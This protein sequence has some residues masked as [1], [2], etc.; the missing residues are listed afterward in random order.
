MVAT[1]G[2]SCNS[3]P[4]LPASIP[5]RFLELRPPR[6]WG[7]AADG[8]P[9]GPVAIEDSSGSMANGVVIH[10]SSRGTFIL[11]N[12]HV[13][14]E[15]ALASMSWLRAPDLE[16][17][18]LTMIAV[19]PVVPD[20]EQLRLRAELD[21]AWRDTDVERATE[22]A[23]RGVVLPAILL[24]LSRTVDGDL[25]ILEAFPRPGDPPLRPASIAPAEAPD[26]RYR[27]VSLH[28]H[29]LPRSSTLRASPYE[30]MHPS[31]LEMPLPGMSGSGVYDADGTLHA[32]VSWRPTGGRIPGDGPS[33][34]EIV[35]SLGRLAT[36]LRH[37]LE[38]GAPLP[39]LARLVG[40]A[41]PL[42]DR[43]RPPRGRRAVGVVRPRQL[44]E[45]LARHELEWLLD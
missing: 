27:I 22:D 3:P 29:R 14:R 23:L 7:A 6:A 4:P 28:P 39:D 36:A 13:A 17:G 45:F 10:A 44:R 1:L 41:S 34:D 33:D 5:D 40:A 21:R 8:F 2:A 20:V 18:E 38:I 19:A 15:L 11:T 25:A 37:G 35:E 43:A 26:A 9:D 31:I 32:L 24:E 30:T 16:G 42:L 12:E